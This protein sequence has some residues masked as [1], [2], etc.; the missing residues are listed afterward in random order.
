MQVFLSN[1]RF[2]SNKTVQMQ[3]Y[4]AAEFEQIEKAKRQLEEWKNESIPELWPQ[5]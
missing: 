5:G 1:R 3:F 4:S 2:R